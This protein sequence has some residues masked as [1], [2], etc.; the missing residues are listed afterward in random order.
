MPINRSLESRELVVFMTQK[1]V[2]AEPMK[3]VTEELNITETK[4]T[5]MLNPYQDNKISNISGETLMRHIF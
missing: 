1:T 3:G 5:A 2:K 4:Y